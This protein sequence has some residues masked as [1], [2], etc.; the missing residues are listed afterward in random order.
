LSRRL[1]I[2]GVHHVTAICADA[3][4]TVAF[5]RDVLGLTVVRDGPSDDDPESRHVWFDAGDGEQAVSFMQYPELPA[6]TD[7][8]G[9]THHFALAVESAEELDGWVAYLR[10]RGV[11][12]SD[13]MERGSFRSTYVRDPDGHLVELATRGPGWSSQARAAGNLF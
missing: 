5:Y 13:V 8:P 4:L 9:G 3:D 10:G 2:R 11:E 12:C 7:G 6:S 1:A